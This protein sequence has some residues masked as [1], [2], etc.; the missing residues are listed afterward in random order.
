MKKDRAFVKK[1]KQ[2]FAFFWFLKST[3]K[4][5]VGNFYHSYGEV[6]QKVKK[7][8][9]F[10]KQ[11]NVT[12]SVGIKLTGYNFYL[13]DLA[14]LFLR[15]CSVGMQDQMISVDCD[16]IFCEKKDYDDLSKNVKARLITMEKLEVVVVVVYCY[17]Y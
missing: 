17:Y 8:G 11:L 5:A 12:G 1:V 14:C 7:V 2:N 15:I 16:V 3:F 6:Y 10:L 9:R 13:V 4:L